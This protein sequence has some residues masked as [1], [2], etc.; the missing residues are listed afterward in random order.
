MNKG[1]G[2]TK[3]K[4]KKKSKGKAN[5]KKPKSELLS[6]DEETDGGGSAGAEVPPIEIPQVAVGVEKA[7]I[8]PT[9]WKKVGGTAGIPKELKDSLVKALIEIE[10]EDAAAGRRPNTLEEDP[11]NKPFAS[12]PPSA[13][14]DPRVL[15]R[16]KI[17][18]ERMRKKQSDRKEKQVLALIDP[19]EAEN[20][21]K[22]NLTVNQLR[23]VRRINL[24]LPHECRD[25]IAAHEEEIA[26]KDE[27]VL[28]E[29]NISLEDMFGRLKQ[30]E[31]FME[32]QNSSKI[33][34]PPRS[35]SAVVAESNPPRDSPEPPTSRSSFW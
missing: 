12:K 17:M 31:K 20:C 2:K 16:Q 19:I 15:R 6:K 5:D 22:Y 27:D 24:R 23:A 30:D 18:L 10:A 21:E 11:D 28:F 4:A 26:F 29:D 13:S 25:I 35:S 7:V 8:D 34:D 1:K 14:S 3:A 9:N 33:D 32:G